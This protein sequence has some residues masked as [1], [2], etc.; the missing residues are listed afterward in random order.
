M[1]NF[2]RQYTGEGFGVKLDDND[3]LAQSQQRMNNLILNADEMVYKSFKE[4]E[5]RFADMTDVD[6]ETY[7]STASADA[8]SNMLQEYNK[9]A[10]DIV[11]K[12]G[13]LQNLTQND[14]Q[15]LNL[16][17]KTL[18]AK[19]KKMLADQ[20][21]YKT[22]KA[23]VERYPDEYD[24]QEW[25]DKFAS[26]YL[27]TGKYPE[28]RIPVREKPFEAILSEYSKNFRGTNQVEL[29]T[30][31]K[32]GVRLKRTIEGNMTIDQAKTAIK[33]MLLYDEGGR[34]N[35]YNKFNSLP[36]EEKKKWLVD[37]TRDNKIDARE[38]KNG[39]VRWAQNNPEFQRAVITETS[40]PY[41]T[42]STPKTG[43]AA[44]NWN[45]G[46]GS[47]NN[48]NSTFD[49][50]DDVTLGQVTFKNFY[51]LGRQSFTSDPQMIQEYL[52]LDTNQSRT[53][54]KATRFE[55]VG[56]SPDKDMIVVKVT[57]RV[58]GLREGKL[59]GL[60]ASQYDDLLRNK[61][62]G[63][64]RELLKKEAG[65]QSQQAGTPKTG[66]KLY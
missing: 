55:V 50:Q 57:D 14:W 60:N 56:Y 28:E 34:K 17:K 42:L 21:R 43:S 58:T 41:T 24:V 15:E 19:Q 66:R 27:Q 35:A 7:L 61:P 9:I 30:V 4:N 10:T 36:V 49:K 48:R 40:T 64:D 53:L 54:N 47:G 59:I 3:R 37:E 29:D 46:I 52:D 22:D 12:R 23:L 11:K 16:G 62:F 33:D 51:N 44:F 31:T 1:A 8:Q 63:I 26:S 38:E 65:A 2:Q 25:N 6:L 32:E 13:G 39:I 5:K 18:E 20:E 45:V